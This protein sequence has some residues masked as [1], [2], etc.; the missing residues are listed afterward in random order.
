MMLKLY[1]KSYKILL[2]ILL[3][4]LGICVWQSFFYVGGEASLAQYDPWILLLGTFVLISGGIAVARIL[5]ECSEKTLS[6]IAIILLM[7]ILVELIV[8]GFGLIYIPPYDLIHVQAEAINMLET[9][10]IENIVYYA[11]YPNQQ[12]ITILLYFIFSCAKFIGFTDYNMVGIIF[13]IFSIFIS[14]CFVYKICCLWSTKAGVISLFLFLIDPMLFSWASYY[15]TDTICMPFMLCGVYMFLCAEKTK[16]S[17]VKVLLFSFSA[18]II[19]IGGKIR[20]TS[21][22]VLIAFVL[23]LFIKSSMLVFIKKLS[24][25]IVGVVCAILFCNLLLSNYG[26]KDKNYEY[27]ITHWVKLGLSE[28]GNG[29]YT[30]ED[31]QS[32][33]AESTYEGKVEE[34]IETIKKRLKN[35]GLSGVEEL[36]LKKITRVWSTA[37]YVEPLQNTVMQYNTLYK[38]TIG[39]SSKA[40]NYWMQIVRCGMLTLVFISIIFEI[41]RKGFQNSWMFITLFGGIVFYIIWEAKPKYSLCFLPIL[42]LIETY[43]LKYIAEIKEVINVKIKKQ[44]CPDFCFDIEKKKR[45][46][47]GVS[48]FI[49]LCTII[50]AG[51]S[52]SKYVAKQ[53]IQKDLRVNQTTSY[54]SGRINEIDNKG[55]MQSFVSNGDFNTTEVSLLNPN[56]I[57]GQDYIL[58]ILS[59]KEK[60]LYSNKF[61][62]DDIKNNEFHTFKIDKIAANNDKFYLK[63]LPCKTYDHNIGINT[64]KYVLY[65]GYKRSPNYYP[66]GNLYIGDEKHK[67]SDLAFIVS[68]QYVDSIFSARIFWGILWMLLILEMFICVYFYKRAVCLSE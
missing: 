36:Y 25:V 29:A 34:N 46:I 26:V 30:S 7:L 37:A 11:K 23:Y 39:R 1:Q 32:T 61:S 43:S 33:L 19:F 31:E 28:A 60:I 48:C 14:V 22:F 4:M 20:I 67:E 62:S 58:E 2:I 35:M 65:T 57:S 40:F 12:P 42:Y 8:F 51:L 9:G 24:C 53:E 49:F 52:Y 64:A 63:I 10:K 27:P 55:I 50:I 3:V 15:Y 6:R 44:E 45:L 18:F 5:Q 41:K 68:D 38:Y 17:K 21:A 56:Q 66:D 54:W 13:N 47:K 16:S 59:D